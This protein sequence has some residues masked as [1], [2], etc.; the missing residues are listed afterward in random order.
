MI[1]IVFIQMQTSALTYIH[2]IREISPSNLTLTKLTITIHTYMLDL[3]RTL[4]TNFIH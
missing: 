4:P 3:E 2:T 1:P